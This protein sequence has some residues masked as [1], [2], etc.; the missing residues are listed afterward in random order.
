MALDPESADFLS[1][2]AS[3]IVGAIGTDG[4]PFAT[5][6][7]GLTVSSGDDVRGRVQLPAEDADA[8]AH[9]AGGGRIAITGTDVPT[10]RS[11]QLKGRV[12]AF[13]AT[14]AADRE[15]FERHSEGFITDVAEQDHIPREHIALMLPTEIIT[16][17]FTADEAYDQT[18][19]PGAGAPL[20][21]DAR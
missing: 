9:L 17:T 5:R 10:L 11:V 12:E 20:P 15:V 3:L 7:W 21:G 4:R 18:P 1:D 8:L 6:G 14:T 13:V 19:G 2:K 16:C